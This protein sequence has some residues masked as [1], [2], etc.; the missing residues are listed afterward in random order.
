MAGRGAC[1]RPF[2]LCLT[3]TAAIRSSAAGSS[4]TRPPAPACAKAMISSRATRHAS[5]PMRSR[6][7]AP[8]GGAPQPA[9]SKVQNDLARRIVSG[10]SRHATPRMRAGPAHVQSGERPAIVTVPEHGP[11]GE[12]LIKTQHTVEDVTA[13]EPE[14]ALEIERAHDL[15]TDHRRLEIG[16]IR[17]HRLDHQ[18]RDGLAMYVPGCA[19]R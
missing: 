10:R 8:S 15:T 1:A 13:D 17:I 14:G 3:S 2:I 11:C 6:N 7:S 19:V 4:V 18:I 9:L 16:C 12:H 5:C